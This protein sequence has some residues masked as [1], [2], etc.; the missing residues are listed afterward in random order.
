MERQEK[1]RTNLQGVFSFMNTIGQF[2]DFEGFVPIQSPI[3]INFE[4][5]GLILKDGKVALAGVNGSFS[6]GRLVAAMVLPARAS[7]RF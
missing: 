3:D 5:L 1:K 6:K 2:R 7:R 4:E